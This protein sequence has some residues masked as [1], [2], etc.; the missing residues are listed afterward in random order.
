MVWTS[1]EDARGLRYCNSLA[2]N[3]SLFLQGL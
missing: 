1:L 2:A 3:S